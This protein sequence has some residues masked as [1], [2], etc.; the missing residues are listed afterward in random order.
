MWSK[1]KN[2]GLFRSR[3]CQLHDIHFPQFDPPPLPPCHGHYVVNFTIST[4]RDMRLRGFIL[5]A[6]YSGRNLAVPAKSLDN[7]EKSGEFNVQIRDSKRTK[8]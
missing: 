2:D 6:T 5:Q 4:V 8:Q 7:I 1:L 3:R